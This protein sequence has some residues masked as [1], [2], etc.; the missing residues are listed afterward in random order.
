[1]VGAQYC[2]IGIEV[3]FGA[4][5]LRGRDNFNDVIVH[6]YESHCEG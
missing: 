1:M 6:G 2:H 3:S 4:F 5:I